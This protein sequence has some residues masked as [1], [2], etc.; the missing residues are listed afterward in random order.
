MVELLSNDRFCRLA[1]RFGL[2][3]RLRYEPLNDTW[4]GPALRLRASRQ[5]FGQLG[6]KRTRLTA[7]RVKA[8]VRV[9]VCVHGDELLL[10]RD[11]AYQVEKEGFAGA[12]L[13]DDDPK[14]RARIS[15]TVGIL[16]QRLKLFD[17]SNL[18]QMLANT[19]D[20]PRTKRLNNRITVLCANR[21]HTGSASRTS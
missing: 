10:Q 6:V 12:V 8:P 20:N 21:A 9:Q 4:Q 7:R 5:I 1:T 17:P 19:R 3:F 2:G 13:A 16:H 18:N 14:P 15:D 11:G